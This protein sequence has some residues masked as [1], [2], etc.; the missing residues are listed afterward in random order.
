MRGPF[1]AGARKRKVEGT[2][3]SQTLPSWS[4]GYG[5]TWSVPLIEEHTATRPLAMQAFTTPVQVQCP[6]L[7]R[8]CAKP[9]SGIEDACCASA[10]NRGRTSKGPSVT[11]SLP[12]HHAPGGTEK[13]ALRSSWSAHLGQGPMAIG[14]VPL[15]GTRHFGLKPPCGSSHGGHD[16]WVGLQEVASVLRSPEGAK[17]FSV[18]RAVLRIVHFNRRGS[19]SL[20]CDST[21]DGAPVLK[22]TVP[23]A[24]CR[25][26]CNEDGS[27]LVQQHAQ[28]AMRPG[29]RCAGR[30]RAPGGTSK[31]SKTTLWNFIIRK[32]TEQNN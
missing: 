15:R 17:P 21:A 6:S 5:P 19:D 18:R 11:H 8:W 32:T 25:S 20:G 27:C 22:R 29:V 28:S 13:C 4:L 31:R 23:H 10:T 14:L 1:R 26:L 16:P 30:W 2:A 24:R 9:C 12:R 3:R 7:H